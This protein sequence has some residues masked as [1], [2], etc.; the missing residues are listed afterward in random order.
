MTIDADSRDAFLVDQATRAD[1]GPCPDASVVAGLVEGALLDDEGERVAAHAALC[2]ACREAIVVLA[3]AGEGDVRSRAPRP[4]PAPRARPRPRRLPPRRLVAIAALVLVGVGALALLAHAPTESDAHA[5]TDARLLAA[6]RD[7]ASAD[8]GLFARF[9]PLTHDERTAAR[10]VRERG[11]LVLLGPREVVLSD[12]PAF[13]WETVPGSTRYEV[14]VLGADDRPIWT[15]AAT[16][17]SLPYP[18][19]EPA[20]EAGTRHAWALSTQGVLGGRTESRAT[21]TV[22]SPDQA[23]AFARARRAITDRAPADLAALLCAHWALRHGL[24]D[25]AEQLANAALADD[26]D[27]DARVE[28]LRAVLRRRGASTTGAARG[29][30]AGTR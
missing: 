9:T 2:P 6:A 26:P 22:A 3:E 5:G 19:D 4:A 30:G 29:S 12:R 17:T 15:R 21:F 10:G 27:D 24:L 18:D 28:T 14:T 11:G 7:L 23:D 16:G 13:R 20:L 25:E 8:P 1:A